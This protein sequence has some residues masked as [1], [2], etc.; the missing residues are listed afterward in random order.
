MPQLVSSS[1]RTA[2]KVSC[3]QFQLVQQ[4]AARPQQQ[5]QQQQVQFSGSTWPDGRSTHQLCIN[6][7][8]LLALDVSKRLFGRLN[9][10][11]VSPCRAAGAQLW[12]LA[13]SAAAAAAFAGRR[14]AAAAAGAGCCCCDELWLD[15]FK[16]N[17]VCWAVGP[18][19]AA[20]ATAA[21]MTCA[22]GGGGSGGPLPAP[23]D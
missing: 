19:C 7:N 14:A 5:Q 9:C 1:T 15:D 6:S 13:W 3:V 23:P 22:G 16:L 21:A 10:V 20:A 2:A 4:A 18:F 11:C 17:I 12:R 8:F